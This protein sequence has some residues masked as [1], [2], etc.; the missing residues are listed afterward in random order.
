MSSIPSIDVQG[1]WGSIP[2]PK[3]ISKMDA[4]VSVLYYLAKLMN[5]KLKLEKADALQSIDQET[6]QNMIE[7]ELQNTQGIAAKEKLLQF[8]RSIF[9]NDPNL[10]IL[11]GWISGYYDSLVEYQDKINGLLS[12]YKEALAKLEKEEDM[13]SGV[14]KKAADAK[15]KMKTDQKDADK[16]WKLA[17][18]NWKHPLKAAEYAKI[19]MAYEAKAAIQGTAYAADEVA[20]KFLHSELAK[21]FALVAEAKD[22]YEKQKNEL[23]SEIK[24]LMA[25]SNNITPQQLQQLQQD[26]SD[27]LKTLK[28]END[29]CPFRRA[30]KWLKEEQN[31]L[32]KK[33]KNSWFLKIDKWID[34]ELKNDEKKALKNGDLVG[35][36]LDK[37]LDWFLDN[38]M[39]ESPSE[40]ASG[41]MN[42]CAFLGHLSERRLLKAMTN[43][44]QDGLKFVQ[45]S[46]M[47]NELINI[48]NRA[49]QGQIT[50]AMAAHQEAIERY[51]K[52]ESEVQML[53]TLIGENTN[54]NIKA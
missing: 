15:A 8:F 24:A 6:M 30:A 25:N 28:T 14:E 36:W 16:Y 51:T 18:E 41:V 35:N 3:G 37:G 26:F 19:A 13:A 44:A 53:T 33:H 20:V 31:K 12:K 38:I 2:N 1:A 32:N 11:K 39:E 27:L 9:A 29:N 34:K 43:V 21:D 10:G 48:L 47:V 54:H 17:K 7:T 46:G 50:Q 40:M 5:G 23:I 22:K 4:G 52:S 42:A 49:S 45:E